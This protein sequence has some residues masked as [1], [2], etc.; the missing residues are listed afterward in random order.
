MEVPR[1]GDG[2][3]PLTSTKA[4][5]LYRPYSTTVKEKTSS[6]QL[7]TSSFQ[8]GEKVKPAQ[9]SSCKEVAGFLPNTS[10][11]FSEAPLSFAWLKKEAGKSYTGNKKCCNSP[12]CPLPE[13]NISRKA[14]PQRK[15]SRLLWLHLIPAPQ[16]KRGSSDQPS[17]I[18]DSR[19][20]PGCCCWGS[21][22]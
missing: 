1:R 5:T 16:S 15:R 14:K 20:I 8:I 12:F 10:V 6:C 19:H 13:G 2:K 21:W 9:S 22:L 4:G 3:G 18:P 17:V 11:H 7:T